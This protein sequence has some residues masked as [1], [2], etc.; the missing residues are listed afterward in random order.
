MQLQRQ[1]TVLADSRAFD[2]HGIHPF[3]SCL[4]RPSTRA[5]K[6]KGQRPDHLELTV[7]G[8]VFDDAQSQITS[9]IQQISQSHARTSGPGMQELR[10]T[11]LI[12]RGASTTI[13]M[14]TPP[15]LWHAL[16]LAIIAKVLATTLQATGNCSRAPVRHQLQTF[17][18]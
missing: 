2:K 5:T 17:S 7:W 6:S 10:S 18:F 8:D 3:R 14:W 12:L 9:Y 15:S 11:L 16:L 4:S 13:L 1:S